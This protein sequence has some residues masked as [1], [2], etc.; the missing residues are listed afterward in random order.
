MKEL[1]EIVK[2]HKQAVNENKRTA[3]ATVVHIEGSSYRQPGARMLITEDGMLTGAISG[4][5]LEGDALRKA[6]LVIANANPVV[7]TYDTSDEDDSKIG[8]GLGCNG[9]IQIL[10]E[11]VIETEPLNPIKLI[12]QLFSKREPAVLAT[13][14]S[15]ED[16]KSK[17]AGTRYLLQKN[18]PELSSVTDNNQ[19]E[20]LRTQAGS[21]FSKGESSIVAKLIES[22]FDSLFFLALP[23]LSIVI[24]GAGNDVIPLASITYTMGWETTVADGRPNYATV[25]R[26]PTATRV[27][28]TKPSKVLDEIVADDRT[29]FLLM[30]HNYNYDLTLLKQLLATPTIYIGILGPRK[31]TI[32]ML[33]EIQDESKKLTSEQLDKIYGPTGLDTGAENAEEI[34]LSICAEINAVINEKFGTKLRTKTD[35]IHASSNSLR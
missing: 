5:C 15:L 19:L 14:F 25:A 4:G 23:S 7:V 33:G 6:L 1:R 11:P 20:L 9:I 10:I 35:P 2:A 21:V 31:K 29:V 16:R 18:G 34:A 3:L 27:L 30:T 32:K 8:I 24:I 28:V 26:F 13:L 22:K 17:S 12:E